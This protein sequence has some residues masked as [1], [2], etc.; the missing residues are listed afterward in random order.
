MA[1]E[2]TKMNE[3]AYYEMLYKEQSLE[4]EASSGKKDDSTKTTP[5]TPKRSDEEV[6]SWS[7][8]FM[9]VAFLSKERSEDPNTKVIVNSFLTLG[10]CVRGLQ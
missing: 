9:C 10:T 8:F 5:K 7:K 3:D 1:A 2:E 4:I 6:L